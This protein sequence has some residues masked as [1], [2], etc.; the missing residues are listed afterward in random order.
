MDMLAYNDG[1]NESIMSGVNRRGNK[2][3][4]FTDEERIE[5]VKASKRKYY[6]NNRDKVAECNRNYLRNKTY[7]KKITNLEYIDEL[8]KAGDNDK[9][10]EILV[11]F[12]SLEPHLFSKIREK[13]IGDGI[14]TNTELDKVEDL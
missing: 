10:R 6:Y 11:N 14:E 5:A 12:I 13:Q 9:L 1:D 8:F 3:I 7:L 2:P 4:Y